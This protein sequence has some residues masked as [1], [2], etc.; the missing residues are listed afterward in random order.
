[1]NL[2]FENHFILDDL[3]SWPGKVKRFL[4]RLEKPIRKYRTIEHKID[5]AL[6][7]DVLLRVNRPNNEY[8]RYWNY[9]ENKIDELIDGK[10]I[11]G[12]HGTRLIESEILNVKF[13]G[14][15]PLS[16]SFTTHRINNLLSEKLISQIVA[17]I[18]I[19]NNRSNEEYR[20]GNVCFN[21][22]LKTLQDERGFIRLYR[23][24]GG[25]ALY[26][27]HEKNENILNELK[28]LGKP[29]I[30][31]ASIYPNEVG[32]MKSVSNKIMNIWLDRDCANKWNEDTDTFVRRE[33]KV[34]DK[35]NI[36]V[37]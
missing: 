17:K 30:V 28:K 32:F 6:K 37:R 33:V 13:N 19:N 5:E 11:V 26:M 36:D 14:L 27:N 12:F 31:V 29:C 24:W 25:E 1:M 20:R 22:C 2:Y 34:L 3:N 9:S 15:K 18:L 4:A 35:R 7:T 23:A 21:H 8:E 16:N 10:M